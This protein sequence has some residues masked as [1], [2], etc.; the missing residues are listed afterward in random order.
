MTIAYLYPEFVG[1]DMPDTWN[2]DPNPDT[3][4][5]RSSPVAADSYQLWAG[6]YYN[7]H[8]N[9]YTQVDRVLWSWT[10]GTDEP[11]FAWIVQL[12]D[13]RVVTVEGGHDYT[14]WDCQS[15]IEVVHVG[16]TEI[17]CARYLTETPRHAYGED[18]N[19]L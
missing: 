5:H 13:G 1:G 7:S 18:R 3:T 19:A 16:A 17:E 12:K 8:G 4:A 14:G 9:L 6:C 11:M 2:D 15:S 10:D